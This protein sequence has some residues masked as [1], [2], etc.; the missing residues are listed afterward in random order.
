MKHML[1]ALWMGNVAPGPNCGVGDHEIET[2]FSLADHA[3]ETLRRTLEP[4][5]IDL[6]EEF[7][8]CEDRYH[9]LLTLQAFCEGFSLAAQLLAE[10]FSDRP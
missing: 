1:E 5:Q 6:L 4:R 10:A 7:I 9:N 3:R 2:A 8:S